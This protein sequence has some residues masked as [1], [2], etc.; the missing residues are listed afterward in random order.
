MTSTPDSRLPTPEPRTPNPGQVLVIGIGNE[1]RRDDGVGIAVARS[2]R[3]L[4]LPGVEVYERCGEGTDLIA[5]WCDRPFV[6]VIDAVSSGAPVGTVHRFE[7]AGGQAVVPIPPARVFR[8]TSHQ[9]G[10]GEAIELGRLLGQLPSRLVV[11]GIESAEFRDGVGL[12]TLVEQAAA[13]VVARV[14]ADC[15]AL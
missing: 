14:T 6:F 8:G 1:F 15:A 5:S 12:S 4:A 3:A 10:L 11:Y 7:L 2:I 9:I 13:E